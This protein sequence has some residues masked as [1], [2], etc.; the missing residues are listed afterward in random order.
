MMFYD[1]LLAKLIAHTDRLMK[2]VSDEIKT[3]IDD[4]D[5]DDDKIWFLTAVGQEYI[6]GFLLFHT[7]RYNSREIAVV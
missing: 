1:R 3:T 2:P 7:N 4:D 6:L 5:D